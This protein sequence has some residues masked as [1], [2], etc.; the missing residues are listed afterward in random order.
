MTQQA[1][2][3][4]LQVKAE[5]IAA[6][7]YFDLVTKGPRPETQLR[8]G[9]PIWRYNPALR[10]LLSQGLVERFRRP[11]GLWLSARQVAAA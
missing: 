3:D 8:Q 9:E 2:I 1:L 10:L 6:R 5:K 11:D 7:V 4:D